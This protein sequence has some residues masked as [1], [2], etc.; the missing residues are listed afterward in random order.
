MRNLSLIFSYVLFPLLTFKIQTALQQNGGGSRQEIAA[1]Q[2][3]LN[4][5]KTKYA[6]DDDEIAV[7]VQTAQFNQQFP[8]PQQYQQQQFVQ[9]PNQAAAANPGYIT[10]DQMKQMLAESQASTA[11]MLAGTLKRN[12]DF[13]REFGEPL[14]VDKVLGYANTHGVDVDTA[15]NDVYDV[16]AKREAK[17]TAQR[18][19]EIQAAVAAERVKWE[20]SRATDGLF[21]ADPNQAASVNAM[22]SVW[23]MKPVDA[24]VT[25]NGQVN[26]SDPARLADQARRGAEVLARLNS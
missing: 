14:D 17:A 18:Q 11:N 3:T 10:Q 15:I 6:L 26:V 23:N 4:K 9:Q 12:N 8:Q 1:Y 21:Q 19:T 7:D 20:Q 5:L 24:P 2:A 22:K 13:F 25:T 16:A